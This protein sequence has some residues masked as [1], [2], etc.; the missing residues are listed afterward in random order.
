MY[1]WSPTWVW[2]RIGWTPSRSF[3]SV[4]PPA[5]KHPEVVY[6]R[7]LPP[8]E[9]RVR[10]AL[11]SLRGYAPALIPL[12]IGFLLLLGLTLGLGYL[13]VRQMDTVGI[14]A[15]DLGLSRSARL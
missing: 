8:E 10:S 3:E 11:S 5:E 7:T 1:L 2:A 15:R 14:H 6:R 13:S 12:I 9:R 4:M